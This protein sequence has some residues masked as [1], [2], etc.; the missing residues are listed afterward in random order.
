M[1]EDCTSRL[2]A[3]FEGAGVCTAYC[4]DA[5]APCPEGFSCLDAGG[6]V[7]VCAPDGGGLGDACATNADCLSGICAVEEGTTYCTRTCDAATP[8]P[9]EFACTPT[10]A[11]DVSVCRPMTRPTP[12]SSGGGCSV[13]GLASAGTPAAFGLLFL[14]AALRRARRRR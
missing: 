9:G 13:P 7:R 8:C 10:D 12:A 4:D 14:G 3:V 6:G 5:S 1:N 11:P 2:C